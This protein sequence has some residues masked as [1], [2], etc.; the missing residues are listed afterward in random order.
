MNDPRPIGG[1][2]KKINRRAMEITEKIS[3]FKMYCAIGKAVF[4]ATIKYR[5]VAQKC[6]Q[7]FQEKIY[8]IFLRE[9]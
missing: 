8:K 6:Q 1:E 2:S 4:G 9:A 5:E 3:T 7:D